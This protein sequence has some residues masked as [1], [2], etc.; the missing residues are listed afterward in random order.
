MNKKNIM[1][2]GKIPPP[3]M[4]PAVATL[5]LLKSNLSETYNIIHVNTKI[6]DDLRN[7][8]KFSI[9]KL[10]NNFS[11]YSS[12]YSKIISK[13]PNLIL[14][15]IS[16]STIG[17]IK[18]SIF[19]WIGIICKKKILLHLRGSDFKRWLNSTSKLNQLFV[20]TTLAKT[21]GVIVLGSNLKP[22]FKDLIPDQNIFVCPNG[23]TYF[24]KEKSKNNTG[25]T[26]LLYIGNLLPGKG[27]EDVLFSLTMLPNAL[28]ENIELIVKGEF[29]VNETKLKCLEI[30]NNN[31]LPVTFM[32]ST[33]PISKFDLLSDADIFLFPPRE[34]EGHPW[35][36][37]EAMAA[38]LPIISTDQGAIIESVIDGAN[39]FIVPPFR[40]DIIAEK[41]NFLISNPIIRTTMGI[42]SHAHYKN[43]FTEE[44]MVEKLTNIFNTVIKN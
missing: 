41:I 33:H 11:L 27:I 37:I 38:S 31:N 15:P 40:P 1:I 21:N 5:I 13:K 24:F 3:F 26:K 44:R 43:E 7:I 36:I 10:W 30:V 17:F 2:L 18:D 19:I 23:G 25:K 16:Q 9:R 29:L 4:G 8:G 12:M 28:L 35:V 34:P 14:I 32:N 22:L 42:A 39:G 20:K 6:N